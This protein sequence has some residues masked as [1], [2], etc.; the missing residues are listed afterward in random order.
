[1]MGDTLRGGGAAGKRG[2]LSGATTPTM[3]AGD[4]VPLW[5][6]R[7]GKA[8]RNDTR[9]GPDVLRWS[10]REEP[11]SVWA[12]RFCGWW[13]LALMMSFARW[14]AAEGAGPSVFNGFV[15]DTAWYSLIS[16]NGKVLVGLERI[17]GMGV[18]TSERGV[19]RVWRDGE[20]QRAYFETD[21]EKIVVPAAVSSD[22]QIIAGMVGPYHP[23]YHAAVWTKGAEG[24]TRTDLAPDHPRGEV[25]VM[26]SDGRVVAGWAG[27]GDG[28]DVPCVW[29]RIDGTWVQTSLLKPSAQEIAKV[30]WMSADGTVLAGSTSLQMLPYRIRGVIWRRTGNGWDMSILPIDEALGTNSRI[31]DLSRDGGCILGDVLASTTFHSVGRFVWSFDGSDWQWKRLPDLARQGRSEPR[32]ISD[33]GDLVIGTGD[34]ND[35]RPPVRIAWRKTE[36]GSWSI[37]S[38]GSKKE[39]GD[40]TDA[41]TGDGKLAFARPNMGLWLW[42]LVSGKLVSMQALIA[43]LD[44]NAAAAGWDFTEGEFYGLGYIRS[45][46]PTPFWAAAAKTASSPPASFRSTR[47]F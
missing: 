10:L 40:F 13:V 47:P 27:E 15:G 20:W 29:E 39:T 41:L 32:E 19:V 12:M 25:T 7:P 26:S 8:G 30:M 44:I 17:D 2:S 45:T 37:L 43:G 38:A 5:L 42:N 16:G 18:P 36:N 11:S 14:L 4:P 33:A 21:F 28:W 35:D 31:S 9:G 6:S 46:T 23:I 22:G 34:R 24:W 3:T 1:M